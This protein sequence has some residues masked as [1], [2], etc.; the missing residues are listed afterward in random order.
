MSASAAAAKA[1]RKKQK[2]AKKVSKV[3]T[4]TEKGKYDINFAEYEDNE[5]VICFDKYELEWDIR[6]LIRCGHM[7][8]AEWIEN[9]IDS[10]IKHPTWPLCK[11]DIKTGELVT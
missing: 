4:Y 1:E 2:K 11:I 3:L 9:W 10:A 8:H 6:K 5:W 7:F